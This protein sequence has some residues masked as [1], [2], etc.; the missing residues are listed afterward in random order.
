MDVAGTAKSVFEG[1]GL[2]V[3]RR[4]DRRRLEGDAY[5]AQDRLL[6]GRPVRVVFDVGANTGQTA[7]KYRSLYPGATV[8]SFEPFADSFAAL[9]AA[10][11]GDDAV[12]PR[13]LAVADAVGTRTF[14]VNAANVTNSLLPAADGSAARAIGP[15]LQ[16]VSS[17][18]VETTTVDDFCAAEAV[19]AIDVLKFD[20]QGGEL[21]ALKGAQGML[22]RRA[23]RLVYTE[24]WFTDAYKGQAHFIDLAAFLRDRGYALHGLYDLH[25]VEHPRGRRLAWADAIFVSPELDAPAAP[26]GP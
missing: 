22:A 20:I 4:S 18:E 25:H 14:Y 3:R 1:L 26:P 19:G 17:V 11:A 24:V 12:K 7:R 13:R 10:F 5:A 21:I 23:I 2:E 8:Y 16:N 15:E 9:S 6:H